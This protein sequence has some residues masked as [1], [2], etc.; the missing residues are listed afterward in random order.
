M[1]TASLQNTANSFLSPRDL[2]RRGIPGAVSVSMF[3][4][5]S[6]HCGLWGP[7]HTQA[8]MALKLGGFFQVHKRTLPIAQLTAFSKLG[9]LSSDQSPYTPILHTFRLT[10][11]DPYK[12]KDLSKNQDISFPFSPKE[13]VRL[14]KISMLGS[15]WFYKDVPCLIKLVVIQSQCIKLH[16]RFMSLQN[17]SKR[18]KHRIIARLCL[19]ATTGF[20]PLRSTTWKRRRACVVETKEGQRGKTQPNDL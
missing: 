6:F 4:Q 2:P 1:E 18:I 10:C 8:W 13:E 7:C 3:C 9:L 16:L 20:V 14:N 12:T 17:E 15:S 5:E 19:H 11:I